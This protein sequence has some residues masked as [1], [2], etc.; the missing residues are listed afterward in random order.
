MNIIFRET[1]KYSQPQSE[2]IFLCTD[3][4]AAEVMGWHMIHFSM[5][6]TAS[7]CG[8]GMWRRYGMQW[9]QWQQCVVVYSSYTLGWQR[10]LVIQYST[11]YVLCPVHLGRQEGKARVK[12]DYWDY[13][14]HVQCSLFNFHFLP[15]ALTTDSSTMTPLR[16][17]RVNPCPGRKLLKSYHIIPMC[18]RCES[19]TTPPPGPKSLFIST[20]APASGRGFMD[21]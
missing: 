17:S 4:Q 6:S 12:G 8:G 19:F 11:L 20:M 15:W 5:A 13:F 7:V 1:L 16:T 14:R 3:V 2:D 18:N 9:R 21:I 10:W